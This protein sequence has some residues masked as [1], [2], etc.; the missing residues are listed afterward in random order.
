MSRSGSATPDSKSL[1]SS[2]RPP[3]QKP[4]GND[5]VP[6]LRDDEDHALALLEDNN[7]SPLNDDAG[8]SDDH[9]SSST[10][11]DDYVEKNRF[12]HDDRGNWNPNTLR[13]QT[14]NHTPFGR[15]L[16][17]KDIDADTRRRVNGKAPNGRNC[18]LTHTA[19]DVDYAH[20]FPRSAKIYQLDHMEAATN[21]SPL[22][23]NVD[24]RYNIFPLNH[25]FHLKY[26]AAKWLLIP[27]ARHVEAFY[28]D[29]EGGVPLRERFPKIKNGLFT[30]TVLALSDMADDDIVRD[31]AQGPVRYRWPYAGLKIRSHVHPRFVVYNAGKKLSEDT[32]MRFMDATHNLYAPGPALLE[33]QQLLEKMVIIYKAWTH[34]AVDPFPRKLQSV[35]GSESS[36][37]PV[38]RR[39]VEDNTE[40]RTASA[41]SATAPPKSTVPS[42]IHTR[43]SAQ[44]LARRGH[45]QTP[46][47]RT[48]RK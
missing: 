42:S 32:A 3:R 12:Q 46:N 40:H 8:S 13:A 14:A 38:K 44:I 23:L 34:L 4:S 15:Q 28:S 47:T 43:T 5:E 35:I 10:D 7:A 45:R 27:E 2:A 22:S 16:L 19:T 41:S 25:D 26:D 11:E 17:T 30:Y 39:R 48:S 33:I 20:N 9:A 37:R 1:S 6:A 21:T 29:S 31:T 24:T 18:I 36:N